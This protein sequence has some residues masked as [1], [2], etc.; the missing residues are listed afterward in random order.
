MYRGIVTQS[1]S[2]IIDVSMISMMCH[3]HVHQKTK[4]EQCLSPQ[5]SNIYFGLQS[6][7]CVFY[8]L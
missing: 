7:Q 5:L 3:L 6:T 4:P 2:I 8:P 1:V